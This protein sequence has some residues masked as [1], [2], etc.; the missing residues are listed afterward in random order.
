[1]PIDAQQ[2]N[3]ALGAVVLLVIVAAIEAPFAHLPLTRLDAFI[4]AVQTV[5]FFA[6]LLTA[7][8]LFAQYSI[9]PRPALLV[10]ASG[11][12]ASGAFAFLQTLAFPGAYAPAGLIGDGLN[13]PAWFFVWWHVTFPAA[14]LI[15]ALTKD[16]DIAPPDARRPTG[17]IIAATVGCVLALVA[18][19]T[20]LAL[21]GHDYLPGL[22]VGGV[23]QQTRFANNINLFMWCWGMTVVVVIFARRRT[24][25]DLWLVVTLFAWMPNFLI[26]WS[27]TTVRFSLGWYS[28]RIF[29]LIASCT[30]LAVLLTETTVLYGRLAN[31]VTLLR[32]ERANRLMSLDAATSAMAH[33]ISQPLTAI[34]ANSSAALISLEK[35]PPALDDAQS[36]LADI[37]DE[38]MRTAKIIASVRNVFRRREGQWQ[39]AS[40]NDVA[41]EILTLLQHDIG[42]S[43]I[44]IST[45]YQNVP[46]V[47]ADRTQ[48]QQVILNLVK[49]AMEAIK[50][51]PGSSQRR[52]HLATRSE[53]SEV[54]LSV[55]DSGPGIAA[56]DQDQIFKP[57]FTTKSTGMG[58]GL[59]FSRTIIE[60]HGG[61][62]RLVK[63]GPSGTV[64]EIALPVSLAT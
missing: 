8:L 37:V 38:T 29:G 28:G 34:S 14:V 55:E 19:L 18:A 15:Y 35:T 42:A 62:L 49:N 24:I 20:W 16:T 11:Y 63:T 22:Y 2:R 47:L 13:S 48:L 25:L 27:V 59:A 23:T 54:V 64:F 41:R 51:A 6:D 43:G 56:A 46:L 12:C 50:D 60:E 39:P 58:L 3:L 21:A 7:I 45:Q 9:Q 61:N 33:E 32:R 53:A 17:L 52:L 10:L 44:S 57:F 26:A 4:P 36:A 30:V 5:I 40:I 31:A 1:M